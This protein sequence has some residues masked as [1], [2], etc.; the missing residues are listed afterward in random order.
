MLTS[1]TQVKV[2]DILEPV[3]KSGLKGIL[4]SQRLTSISIEADSC[5]EPLASLENIEC[6][7]YL[8][9]VPAGVDLTQG[10]LQVHPET[11]LL[12]GSTA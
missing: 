3:L 4:E 6:E 10:V 5:M 9:T 12:Q 1:L 2:L 7:L 11:D 8:R